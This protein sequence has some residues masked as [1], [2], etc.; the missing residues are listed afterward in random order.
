LKK[1]PKRQELYD[2]MDKKYGKSKNKCWKD[3]SIIVPEDGDYID[4][5][6]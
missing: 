3:V 2:A 5:I 1:L 6:Y 4:N